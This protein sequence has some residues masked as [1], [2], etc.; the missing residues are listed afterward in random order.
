MKRL[1]R[2]ARSILLFPTVFLVY[3]LYTGLRAGMPVFD[4]VLRFLIEVI[5]V[6]LLPLTTLR[7]HSLTADELLTLD[8][9]DYALMT[10][11]VLIVWSVAS[12]LLLFIWKRLRGRLDFLSNRHK[13]GLA[14]AIVGAAAVWFLIPFLPSPDSAQITVDFTQSL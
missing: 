6:S 4:V 5:Y 7:G 3:I 2:T 9:V 11:I 1:G 14:V 8:V 13:W 10:A 12:V